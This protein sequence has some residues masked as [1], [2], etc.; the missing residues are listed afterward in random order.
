MTVK[1][2][3]PAL[4]LEVADVAVPV[5]GTE[6]FTYAIPQSLARQI[7]PGVRVAVPFKNR[8]MT[9]YVV[10]VETREVAFKLKPVAEVLDEEPVLSPEILKLT[11][12][13]SSY[14]GSSWGESIENA[15]PAWVKFGRKAER[16]L[17]KLHDVEAPQ[18]AN[19]ETFVLTP[20][21]A[22]AMVAADSS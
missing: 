11:G 20:E 17:K 2:A 18:P 21:Q 10:K 19:A 9:A 3:A 14:Y 1:Q 7:K 22:S 16:A 6:V 15:L 12:Q 8:A 5:P 13:I 4:A